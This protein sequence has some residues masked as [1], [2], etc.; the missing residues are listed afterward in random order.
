M[1]LPLYDTNP[2]R[3]FPGF[4][5]AIIAANVVA[6][7][8]VWQMPDLRQ[9]SF[10]AHWGFVPQR[11]EQLSDPKLV[12]EVPLEP[13]HAAAGNPAAPPA[14]GPVVR[15][16][17]DSG[18]IYGSLFAM[19]FLHANLLHLASNMWMFWIFGNNVEDR[20]GHFVFL[21]FYLAGG[22]LANLCQ[23]AID[24][25]STIPVIGASGAVAAV[26]G[27]YAIAFPQ[28]KVRTLIFLVVFITLVDL[29]A[30]AVLGFWFIT[31]LLNG[32]NVFGPMGID[33]S[34]GV[35]WRAHIGGFTA[36]LVLMPVLGLGRSPEGAHLRREAEEQFAPLR[37]D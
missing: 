34:G 13:P 37:R 36:G 21:F 12:V 25:A 29:P 19:M 20:L 24:P 17:A 31:Q 23:W 18:Q 10:I 26:L 2:H 22:L 9:Q 15:L 14:K 11:I 33:L 16:A 32:L 5:L 35:A 7:I 1:F 6:S 3:R 4:T 27:G 8:A 30:F 28:A